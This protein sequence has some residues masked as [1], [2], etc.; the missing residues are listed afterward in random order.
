MLSPRSQGHKQCHRSWW[1]ATQ[2]LTSQGRINM[3]EISLI[4]LHRY[5][6][7]VSRRSLPIDGWGG[8]KKKQ[9]VGN[10][11]SPINIQLVQWKRTHLPMQETH[12]IRVPSLGL[13]DAS[14]VGNGNLLQYSCQEYPMDRGAWSVYHGITN[15]ALTEWLSHICVTRDNLQTVAHLTCV[16]CN[17]F[18]LVSKWNWRWKA[19][20]YI[21]NK[22]S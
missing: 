10:R 18:S 19:C 4:M 21:L 20:Q 2:T 15:L 12:E 1:C 8:E 11:I 14:G 7:G 3:T 9:K 17:G 5:S 22:F 13:E 6:K 16:P